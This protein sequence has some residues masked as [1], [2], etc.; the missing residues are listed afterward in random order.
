MIEM[1]GLPASCTQVKMTS[2]VVDRGKHLAPTVG[3]GVVGDVEGL[4]VP[5]VVGGAWVV[6]GA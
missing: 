2:L 3:V 5:G 6:G 1:G 4:V